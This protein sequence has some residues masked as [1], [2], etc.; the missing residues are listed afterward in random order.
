MIRSSDVYLNFEDKNNLNFEFLMPRDITI[1]IA[2][3]NE[4]KENTIC[5][6]V[7]KAWLEIFSS[8]EVKCIALGL[9]PTDIDILVAI[10]KD[11]KV[12]HKQKFN[13]Y[14]LCKDSIKER[15]FL[16]A[17]RCSLFLNDQQVKTFQLNLKDNYDM[18]NDNSI[19]LLCDKDQ[20]DYFDENKLMEISRL[21]GAS[22]RLNF[23][24]ES[25]D[26]VDF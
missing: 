5:K 18:L 24:T 14:K 23:S 6:L 1:N 8:N 17:Q 15:Q 3:F 2:R 7:S 20:Q 4:I 12:L 25:C 26:L 11:Q 19:F 9:L 10:E 21:D 16:K 22:I 13:V